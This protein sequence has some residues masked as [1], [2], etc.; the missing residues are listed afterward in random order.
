MSNK[1]IYYIDLAIEKA[2]EGIDNYQAP[3]GA[4]IVRDNSLLALEYNKVISSVDITAHAE[5][6]AIRAACK[7]LNN[8][9]LSGSVIYSTCEPCPMCFAACHWAKIKKIVYGASIKDAKEAGFDELELSNLYLKNAG[10][11]EIDIVPDV[12]AD[13]CKNLFDLWKKSPKRII[14]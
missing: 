10:G 2:K 5:I 12:L 3:F 11:L 6:V 13:K 8:I 14:Y 9:N 4:C 1:D 7:E